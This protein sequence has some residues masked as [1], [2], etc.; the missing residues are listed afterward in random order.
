MGRAIPVKS[1]L[2]ESANMLQ[3]RDIRKLIG[4]IQ[5]GSKNAPILKSI[6]MTIKI[7]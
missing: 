5:E 6:P 4:Q 1:G 7:L 3:S 2:T